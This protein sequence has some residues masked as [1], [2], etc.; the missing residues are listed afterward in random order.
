MHRGAEI[1]PPQSGFVVLQVRLCTARHRHQDSSG[2]GMR[3]WETRLRREALTNNTPGNA[4]QPAS[5]PG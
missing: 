2:G 4:A 1:Q 3:V 5:H